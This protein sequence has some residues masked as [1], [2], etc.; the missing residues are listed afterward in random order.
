MLY[1]NI[2]SSIELLLNLLTIIH[3]DFQL[4]LRALIKI[5]SDLIVIILHADMINIR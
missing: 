2:R 1:T 5:Y 3:T 4:E